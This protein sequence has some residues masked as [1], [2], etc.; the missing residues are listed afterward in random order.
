M[1]EQYWN[2]MFGEFKTGER[3]FSIPG[4]PEP[5]M[6][7]DF[8]NRNILGTRPMENCT[9]FL[10][11]GFSPAS[12]NVNIRVMP[13]EEAIKDSAF[14]SYQRAFVS[15][16]VG[17]MERLLPFLVS[18]KRPH[19]FFSVVEDDEVIATAFGGEGNTNC[20]LFNLKVRDGFE[21]QGYAR[22]LLKGA[23]SHFSGKETFYWTVHPTFT[24][25]ASYI[26][27]YHLVPAGARDFLSR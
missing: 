17:F 7:A 12:F 8:E 5:L 10:L 21:N 9:S 13:L 6:S 15:E 27:G 20:F 24:L 18:L 2:D 25:G 26:E 4:F 19:Y 1:I 23:R 16:T 14:W 22:H 3:Q 11:C